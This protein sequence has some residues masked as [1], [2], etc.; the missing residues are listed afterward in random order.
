MEIPFADELVATSNTDLAAV[1]VFFDLELP[2]HNP[3]V[4]SDVY[5][6]SDLKKGIKKSERRVIWKFKPDRKAFDIAKAFTDEAAH[7]KFEKFLSDFPPTQILSEADRTY[8]RSLHSASVARAGC[9]ILKL[10]KE[11]VTEIARIPDTALWDV[12]VWDSGAIK[13]MVPKSASPEI[14]AKFLEKEYED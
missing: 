5:K 12:I 10:R 1:F 7:D 11:L 4:A 9:E 6:W 3:G 8:L 2:S 13:A 14:K